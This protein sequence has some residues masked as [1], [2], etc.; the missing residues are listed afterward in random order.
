VKEAHPSTTS[1][2]RLAFAAAALGVRAN[3]RSWDVSRQPKLVRISENV[4]QRLSGVLFAAHFR[5]SNTTPIHVESWPCRR[6]SIARIS[7]MLY[8]LL[9]LFA[10]RI[11][12]L[13]RAL[14]CG[15][16]ASSCLHQI[17][18]GA[19][20]GRHAVPH[21]RP[22][23]MKGTS[24]PFAR[25]KCTHP[26]G[27]MRMENRDNQVPD[28]RIQCDF[29]VPGRSTV[30]TQR[31]NR[32]RNSHKQRRLVSNPDHQTPKRVPSMISEPGCSFRIT[33]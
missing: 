5:P 14:N 2:F 32:R 23:Q 30:Q 29:S 6:T 4:V 27:K 15:P 19:F 33:Q 31:R 16:A 8:L 13:G 24:I 1:V 11:L 17:I 9:H 25:K 10:C 3:A 22:K 21:H 12:G 18:L 28:L 26:C 20:S 7:A